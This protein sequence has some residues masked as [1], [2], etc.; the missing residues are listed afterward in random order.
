MSGESAAFPC[1]ARRH[2]A[3]A[4]VRKTRTH[5]RRSGNRPIVGK[6]LALSAQHMVRHGKTPGECAIRLRIRPSLAGI[7]AFPAGRGKP[8]PYGESF[9]ISPEVAENGGVAARRAGVGAPYRVSA[10]SPDGLLRF[11]AA[12]RNAGDGIPYRVCADLPKAEASHCRCCGGVGTPPPTR[13]LRVRPFPSPSGGRWHPPI[14]REA[15][16][17]RGR[18]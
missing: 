2:G 18:T 11:S 1:R 14:P 9:A 12:A 10:D 17:G 16:D 5:I 7:G 8:L 3:P 4:A 6:G 13:P 15:D